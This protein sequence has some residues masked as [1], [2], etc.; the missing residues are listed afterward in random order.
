MYF[1]II[2]YLYKKYIL[3]L[4]LII[5]LLTTFLYNHLDYIKI[6]INNNL[7][8]KD[9]L[10]NKISI[11]IMLFFLGSI[12]LY[13]INAYKI[14]NIDKKIISNF[15]SIFISIFLTNIS[16]TYYKI[17]FIIYYCIYNNKLLDIIIDNKY[18]QISR[19]W[20]RESLLLEIGNFIQNLELLNKVKLNL[21]NAE[22]ESILS[23][24]AGIEDALK[25]TQSICEKKLNILLNNYSFFSQILGF[26]NNNKL[27]IVIVVSI[28]GCLIFNY[29]NINA[30]SSTLDATKTL[31]EAVIKAQ[32][33][34][35]V[36]DNINQ[37][38]IAMSEKALELSKKA[39]YNNNINIQETLMLLEELKSKINQHDISLEKIIANVAK[40]NEC[41]DAFETV[42]KL[43]IQ[44]LEDRGYLP[45]N[46]SG[47]SKFKAF[48]GVGRSLSD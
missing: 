1:N 33:S 8:I 24:S 17:I 32:E 20:N 14:Y 41:D 18:I 22:F 6:S 31:G 4:N 36:T 37:H 45:K 27:N 25:L 28:V 15:K 34:Q 43:L 30:T 11:T 5:V 2:N 26:I 7:S 47:I 35:V 13:L 19:I 16:I 23:N 21:T 3:L 10:L 9:I 29:Y 38:C 48:S 12:L 42:L 39:I 44:T 40:L 46:L